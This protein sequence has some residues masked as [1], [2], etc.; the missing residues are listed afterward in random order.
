MGASLP[1][2]KH[3]THLSAS[4]EWIDAY[5]LDTAV[6]DGYAHSKMVEDVAQ[7]SV[8]A[9]FDLNVPEGFRG[10]EP[11]WKSVKHQV[12]IVETKQREAGG[13]LIPG[14]RCVGRFPSSHPVLGGATGSMN[15]TTGALGA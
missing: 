9:A 11:Q 1:Q 6:P 5:N 12:G 10:A 4:K 13:L 2:D 14:G 8:V 3:K 7:V 15:D